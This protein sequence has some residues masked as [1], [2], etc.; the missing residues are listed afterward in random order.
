MSRVHSRTGL[1][2]HVLAHLLPSLFF[3]PMGLTSGPALPGVSPSSNL[4]E[5]TG[6]ELGN[7]LNLVF[8]IWSSSQILGLFKLDK[9]RAPTR[10]THPPASPID[11]RGKRDRESGEDGSCTVVRKTVMSMPWAPVR[12]F[13]LSSHRCPLGI[14]I[15]RVR[16]YS[17]GGLS[18]CRVCTTRE[19]RL[20]PWAGC[21]DMLIQV[22]WGAS[23]FAMVGDSFKA[24]STAGSV[25]GCRWLVCPPAIY[26]TAVV[27]DSVLYGVWERRTCSRW[28]GCEQLREWPGLKRDMPLRLMWSDPYN[29]HLR[30]WIR[31]GPGCLA[32]IDHRSN[33]GDR[34]PFH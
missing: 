9:P 10:P 33:G 25:R 5:I 3:F 16:F 13:S 30:A 2:S 21:L 14:Q 34:I 32:C 24:R 17:P 19:R 26:A 29:F 27:A 6:P 28:I 23:R 18:G 4:M 12:I 20:T 1:N 8:G 22:V 15:T 11:A 7:E 31:S